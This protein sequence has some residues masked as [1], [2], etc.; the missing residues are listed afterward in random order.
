MLVAT[1]QG[2]TCNGA[3]SEIG[4][5]LG[6]PQPDSVESGDGQ[7]ENAG[8]MIVAMYGVKRAVLL[9]KA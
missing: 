9:E 1:A 8:V 3:A 6:D 4:M 7:V 2:R 5:T